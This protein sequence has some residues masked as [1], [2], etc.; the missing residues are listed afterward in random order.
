[1]VAGDEV[2]KHPSSNYQAKSKSQR[3]RQTISLSSAVP[4]AAAGV[5]GG[6]DAWPARPDEPRRYSRIRIR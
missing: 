2:P 5:I 1:M 3:G 6:F 4:P